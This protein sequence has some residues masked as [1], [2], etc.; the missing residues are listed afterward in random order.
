M[1]TTAY[2]GAWL[3]FSALA[4]AEVP[5]A[6]PDAVPNT[7]APGEVDNPAMVPFIVPDPATLPGI[8]VDESAAELVGEWAY[9]THTP[10]YV[11]IG[12][13]HD[14]KAGKGE[15]SATFTPDLPAA[16][17]YEV[18]LA[19]CHNV[20]RSR[21]APITIRHADGETT[22]RIDQQA[23]PEHGKLFRT[24]GRFRFEAGKAGWVRVTNGRTEADK[25]VIADAVQFL[26]VEAEPGGYAGMSLRGSDPATIRGK[27]MCGYQGWF[28]CEGDGNGLGWVHW[29]KNPGKPFAPGNVAVDLWPDVSE[30]T[31]AER[32][33]T[34]F[35]LANGETA[36]VFSS[37][38]LETVRRHFEW[39]REH[40]ID[41]V[42]LQR[43]ANGLAN[44]GLTKQK[45]TVLT[46]V[47]EA[48]NLNGRTY[49]VMYDLSGLKQGEVSRVKDDWRALRDEMR[50]GRDPAYQQ[51][52]GKPLVAVWGIGFSDDR[53]YSLDEC[54]DLIASLKADGCAVMLGVPSWWR[55]GVRDA[56][57]D[58]Q[59]KEICALADIL[60]PWSVGR[61][62][63]PDGAAR[64][65]ETVWKA[66]V[67]WCRERGIDLL[68]VAFP[69]FSWRNL[70][71]G[72]EP[73]DAIPRLK[74]R[75]LW[76]Q[77]VSAKLAG[78]E[79]V[80]VAMFDEVDE[81]TAIFKC[82]ND[83]PTGEGVSFLTY[84]GLPSDFYLKLTGEGA[85]LMRGEL[86]AR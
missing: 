56:V 79:S 13:L 36:H 6:H 19:H 51:H 71:G 66:D 3:F 23:T 27:A 55:D 82:T 62:R 80:Y 9:S 18:R 68:P 5:K 17:L 43:F 8:V 54:R 63:D 41:G 15:K 52:E 45:N 75:F 1:R 28:T 58:P 77:F 31:E 4:S 59:L 61:Y 26:P 11:G 21:M 83:V 32:H 65:G 76:S 74:G 70:K 38:N 2:L 73:L 40:G 22:V 60:N 50:I 44:P 35:R 20:R 85:K 7:H 14:Q 84:D 46:H 33:A 34:G 12:Y 78:A 53:P 48:A 69:G 24:L 64:H 39:M 67:A 49:A 30:L 47:R 72:N 86:P 81:G 29:A 16:G 37:T 10:P 42:F 57:A 25:V